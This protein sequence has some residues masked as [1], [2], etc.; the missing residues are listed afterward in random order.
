M[1]AEVVFLLSLIPMTTSVAD[2]YSNFWRGRR[3][4][5]QILCSV[6]ARRRIWL[7]V[8][9][10]SILSAMDIHG[11]S[12]RDLRHFLSVLQRKICVWTGAFI[13]R[14]SLMQGNRLSYTLDRMNGEEYEFQMK[15]VFHATRVATVP[16][17]L[18]HHIRWSH[19][20]NYQ[21]TLRR[22]DSLSAINRLAGYLDTNRAPE[23]ASIVR[24]N[25]LPLAYM[26]TLGVLVGQGWPLSYVTRL[27]LNSCIRRRVVAFDRRGTNNQ[28]LLWALFLHVPMS[29]RSSCL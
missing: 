19:S 27:A 14:R 26:S 2:S 9:L 20:P 13:V 18:G 24:S 8:G 3:Q 21:K 10:G 22:F 17:D 12:C 29:G 25:T 15:C 5:R 7:W 16:Q 11:Y 6:A 1:P 28:L 4:R 23:L